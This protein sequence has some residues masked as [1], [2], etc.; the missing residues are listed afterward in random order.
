[1]TDPIFTP[2]PNP[3][4][5]KNPSAP[6][7]PSQLAR[8]QW[9]RSERPKPR[10]LL[11]LAI[12]V[13]SVAAGIG[14]TLLVLRMRGSA[15][16]NPSASGSTASGAA[17]HDGHATAPAADASGGHPTKAGKGIVYISSARQQMIGVRTAVIEHQALGGTV[18]TVGTVA[19][20]ETRVTMVN[21][22]IA[23]WVDRVFVDYVG[24]A[25]RKGQPLFSVY[26]P[27]LVST[28]KE[29]LLALKARRQLAASE[30]EDTR[31]G[32][33]S[34]VSAARERLRLWDVT[35][36][37]VAELEHSGEAR[38]VLTVYAPFSGIVQERSVFPGQYVTPEM[39]TFKIADLSRVWVLAQV[40]EYEAPLLKLGLPATIEFPYGQSSRSLQGQVTYVYPEV[41]AQTRRVQIRAEFKNPGL[42]FKPNTYV[43][44][45]LKTAAGHQLAIPR[46]AVIDTG[47][48]RYAILAHPNGYFEP[49]E[50]QVGTPAGDFLPVTAGLEAGDRVVTSAQFLIDSETNLQSAMQSMAMSMPGM[51]MGGD[52]EG[53]TE[54]GDDMKGMDMGG[55]KAPAPTPKEDMP[56][57]DMSKPASKTPDHAHTPKP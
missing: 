44:V 42:E 46:E 25:V 20:D 33:E 7:T 23:G 50:V 26:S 45:T 6:E 17:S 52:K 39:T 14:G 22:K 40:F 9:I 10:V 13:M 29:Y 53:G 11:L 41:D 28:Q 36:A 35:D 19:F 18:R 51:D 27:E 12:A 57:M 49:R 16:Q 4:P 55:Q 2:E 24:K 56:G 31:A 3:D 21:T 30:F 1:M 48:K 8:S 5:P 38:R 47:T 37:Q 43:T 15:P 54:T 32:A 34:L